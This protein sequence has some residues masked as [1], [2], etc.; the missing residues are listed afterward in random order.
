M[1]G[2]MEDAECSGG[3]IIELRRRLDR[4][5]GALQ[6]FQ[7]DRKDREAL[8]EWVRPLDC[9][10]WRMLPNQASE[11]TLTNS[12]GV[13]DALM[14]GDDKPVDVLG[15]HGLTQARAGAVSLP[16]APQPT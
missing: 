1:A 16:M 6:G 10:N 14:G 9:K 5:F 4:M 15:D 11:M 8:P 13:R 3:G 12:N 2:A 7:A